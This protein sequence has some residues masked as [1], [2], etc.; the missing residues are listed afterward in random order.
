MTL[1]STQV[2]TCFFVTLLGSFVWLTMVGLLQGVDY[3][4]SERGKANHTPVMQFI[5]GSIH[6]QQVKESVM[7]TSLDSKSVF[8]YLC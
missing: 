4:S 2:A 5:L 1:N 6:T 8:V 3:M 7:F